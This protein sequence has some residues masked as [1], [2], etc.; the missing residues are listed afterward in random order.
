[1]ALVLKLFSMWPLIN[2][3]FSKNVQ[4]AIEL[5]KMLLFLKYKPYDPCDESVPKATTWKLVQ[6][7]EKCL[8][9]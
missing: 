5:N 4:P 8:H 7:G 9:T 1:M 6:K 3:L 2:S